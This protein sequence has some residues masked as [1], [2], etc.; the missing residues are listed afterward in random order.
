MLDVNAGI[1]FGGQ[2]SDHI[3]LELGV[4]MLHLNR[5]KATFFNNVER[6]GFRYQA[7]AGV[8]YSINDSWSVN[9]N[10]YY[11]YEKAASEIVVGSLAGYSLSSK[12]SYEH[13][14]TL[15]IG[16][17]YRIKDALSPIVG[18]SFK[19]LRVLLNYDIVLSR[20][21]QPGRANGGPEISVVYVGKWGDDRYNGEKIYCPKFNY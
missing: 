10:G 7:N 20:L 12:V 11:G 21:L 16:A 3:K 14:H 18:Y 15:Y 17:Y 6:I 1:N 2:L 13:E 5:P 8:K 4:A 9:V 19:D